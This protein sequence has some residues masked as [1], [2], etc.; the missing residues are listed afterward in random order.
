MAPV[1]LSAD[2]NGLTLSSSHHKYL[3]GHC[4]GHPGLGIFSSQSNL[5]L[6]GRNLYVLKN[7]PRHC[8]WA[9]FRCVYWWH[10]IWIGWVSSYCIGA[11]DVIIS[12]LIST[13]L[14]GC[15]RSSWFSCLSRCYIRQHHFR[16]ATIWIWS[17]IH[18]GLDPGPGS[19]SS[20]PDIKRSIVYAFHGQSN[21][22][23]EYLF[24]IWL[25]FF[26]T[27]HA[28]ISGSRSTIRLRM[29]SSTNL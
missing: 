3:T 20:P 15:T 1:C 25:S 16:W 23:C 4:Q 18:I 27:S 19:H 24:M 12:I 10:F 21:Q 29:S 5:Q 8:H 9:H 28:S 14:P 7:Y 22:R 6:C 26:D 13:L 11:Y 17:S 2:G